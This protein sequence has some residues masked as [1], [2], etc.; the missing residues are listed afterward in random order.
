MTLFVVLASA[1]TALAM[2]VVLFGP[3]L[4][5]RTANVSRAAVN[6][7]VLRQQL[8]ELECDRARGLLDEGVF[9]SARDELQR[10][11]VTEAV[12]ADAAPPARARSRAMLIAVAAVLPLAAI[13]LYGVYGEPRLLRVPT[14]AALAASI[15]SVA[16]VDAL[17]QLEAQVAAA[18]AD[19]RAWVRL[20]RLR[21]QRD[22][23]EPA[24]LAYA[25]ALEV[26]PKVAGDPQIWCEYADALG[27][28]AGGRLAGRP[29][30]MI[31]KAL[32]LDA[33]HPRALEMAGSAAYETDDFRSA[34]RYWNQLLGQLPV[35]STEHA[36]LAAA[37]ARAERR[38]QFALPAS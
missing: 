23:F 31:D 30:E 22:L 27:M 12:A 8:T 28:A 16:D 29:R 7:E 36:Q 9:A 3:R 5:R 21:M 33:R 13:A 2:A 1:L 25:R 32:A 15:D 37:V 14:A 17:A 38:A 11:L 18:P 24:A 26:S 35:D 34:V 4:G 20:A 19:G 10:R 6:V